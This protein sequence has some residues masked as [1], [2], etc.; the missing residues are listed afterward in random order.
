MP[1]EVKVTPFLTLYPLPS[2]PSSSPGFHSSRHGG[3]PAVEPPEFYGSQHTGS[4]AAAPSSFYGSQHTGSPA[5]APPSFRGSQH[6]GSLV[7]AFP[8]FHGSQHDGSSF[9]APSSSSPSSSSIPSISRLDIGGS[10]PTTFSAVSASSSRRKQNLG[11]DAGGGAQTPIARALGHVT[12]I[13]QILRVL[14]IGG[15]QLIAV[16]RIENRPYATIEKKKRLRFTELHP[17]HFLR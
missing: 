15:V 14:P 11:G 13:Y 4:P 10:R 8:R 2:I 5:A 7:V 6:G 16:A 9:I 17:P 1:K 12:A 3:S